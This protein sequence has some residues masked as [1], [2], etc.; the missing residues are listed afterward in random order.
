MARAQT[1]RRSGILNALA[2]LFQRIDGGDGYK[3][4]LTG[5]ISTRMRFW[6]EVDNF[7][8]LH[9]SAG[10][11]TR[12]YYGGG[13]KF[14]FLTVTLRVYVNSED[15]I[16]ELEEVLEDIETIIDDAGQFNYE[17]S[18]G[19]Q[20]IMQTS[21]VSIS[22]DEGVLAPLGVGEMILEIRY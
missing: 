17:Q 10:T 8:S 7:P 20:N 15:P 22:T 14:R 12:E 21:I 18:E 4:D 1:T 6:D 16:E 2:E 19:S 3:T 9:M 5:S 13:Q 11:E